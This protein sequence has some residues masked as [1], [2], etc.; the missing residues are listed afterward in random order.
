MART[1]GFRAAQ[2]ETTSQ[3]EPESSSS[4]SLSEILP[5]IQNFPAHFLLKSEFSLGFMRTY[6]TYLSA[7]QEQDGHL[8]LPYDSGICGC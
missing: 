1:V 2:S 3:L 6:K 7:K 8:F 5:G 4:K